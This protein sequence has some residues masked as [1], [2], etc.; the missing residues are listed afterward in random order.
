MD[1]CE[2]AEVCEFAE[3]VKFAEF[4]DFVQYLQS[5]RRLQNSMFAE[6]FCLKL[7]PEP[8]LNTNLCDNIVL[9]LLCPPSGKYSI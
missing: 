1:I 8:N 9:V 6:Y 4:A 5:L 3:S 7:N 2:F